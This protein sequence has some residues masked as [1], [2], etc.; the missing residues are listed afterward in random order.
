MSRRIRYEPYPGRKSP[1][2]S[3]SPQIGPRLRNRPRQ[4]TPS[5]SKV[6][7]TT[8]QS[9]KAKNLPKSKKLPSVPSTNNNHDNNETKKDQSQKATNL[10][11]NKKPSVQTV[12]TNDQPPIKENPVLTLSK[13][14]HLPKGKAV[15]AEPLYDDL[16]QFNHDDE[17]DSS[18]IH[19]DDDHWEHKHGDDADS[20]HMTGF[21]LASFNNLSSQAQ[22]D[23]HHKTLGRQ[24]CNVAGGENQFNACIVTM[25]SELKVQSSNGFSQ[26]KSKR[27]RTIMTTDTTDNWEDSYELRQCIRLIATNCITSP[28]VQAYTATRDTLGKQETLPRSLYAKTMTLILSKPTKW[29][30]R[31]LPPAYGID[32]DPRHTA[33]F[34]KAI[35]KILKDIRKSFEE[36]LLTE[37][38][39]P[40]R[41]SNPPYGNVPLLEVMIVKLQEKKKVFVGGPI[42]REEIVEK[43]DHIQEARFAWLRMQVCHW[44]LGRDRYNNRSFWKV[45]DAHLEFLRG[46][47][48]RYRYAYFTAVLQDDFDRI[49]WEKTFDEL[50]KH[51]DFSLPSNNRIE[52]VMKELDKTFGTRLAPDE[53]AHQLPGPIEDKEHSVEKENDPVEEVNEPVGPEDEEEDEPEEEEE[54]EDDEEQEEDGEDDEEQEEDGEDDEEEDL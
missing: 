48:T 15:Q 1:N 20:T 26:T 46:Q 10:Q 4:P 8:T 27:G 43:L 22:L 19:E 39:L 23:E 21:K 31:L 6:Q 40:N 54:E 7:K 52:K 9:Q 36:T 30:K 44:G 33:L 41:K 18:R 16:S 53:A 2:E 50:K 32:P 3:A 28:D 34:Q 17:A 35:N 24:I 51:C 12:Q 38:N 37:I 13:S 45:V 49:T 25:L 42:V 47:T 11:K 5:T 29:K 14:K